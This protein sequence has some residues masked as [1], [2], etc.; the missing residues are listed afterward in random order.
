MAGRGHSRCG[1]LDQRPLIQEQSERT[2]GFDNLRDEVDD[3][4]DISLLRV[5]DVALW[6]YGERYGT[7]LPVAGARP[8]RAAFPQT[9]IARCERGGIGCASVAKLLPG[10]RDKQ[11]RDVAEL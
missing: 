8:K 6:M 4:G 1:G 3:I 9:P 7:T 2:A 11:N 5:L 10:W